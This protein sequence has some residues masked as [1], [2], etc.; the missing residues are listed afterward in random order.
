MATTQIIQAIKKSGDY[1]SVSQK[2]MSFECRRDKDGTGVQTFLAEVFDAG[3]DPKLNPALRYRCVLR[4]LPRQD[5]AALQG[6]DGCG[7]TIELAICEAHLRNPFEKRQ[8]LP[9]LAPDAKGQVIIKA[10]A[11]A[12]PQ[13]HVQ[14]PRPKRQR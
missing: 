5:E 2:I 11:T 9:N 14:T 10:Q 6:G 3:E 8:E 1:F 4:H 7:E 12:Q 13:A